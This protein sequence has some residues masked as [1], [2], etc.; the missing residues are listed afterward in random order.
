M[1]PLFSV[2]LALPAYLLAW[3]VLSLVPR[4][5]LGGGPPVGSELLALTATW[6]LSLV[7]LPG[8]YL[9]RALPLGSRR[10][11]VALGVQAAVAFVWALVFWLEFELG[12]GLLAL[13]P[14]WSS[15]PE[16]VAA[17][18]A[19]LL[20]VGMMLS[21]LSMTFH[22]LVLSVQARGAALER[23]AAALLAR[24][25][26]ELGALRA[27]VHP[28][29][30][31][32]SLNTV[33]AL[34]GYDPARAR[35]ACIEL[36][37]YLR[38]TLSAGEHPFT[39]LREEWELAESYLG[40]EALRLGERLQIEPE[41]EPAALDHQVPS[42][43][44][45]PLI[46][47]AITHGV[48]QVSEP[49]PLVLRAQLRGERLLIELENPCVQPGQERAGRPGGLGLANVR[50]RLAAH[51]GSLASLTTTRQAS[52]FRVRLDLPAVPAVGGAA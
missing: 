48:S 46:E 30:L 43:V 45:Q 33:S 35:E 18:R 41:F 39:S 24:Q 12:A 16:V 20:G 19:E 50:A 15:L 8:Y 23:E 21:L 17:R 52:T 4:V 26:A 42:L 25:R 29:F 1:H 11:A 51:Y 27:Q 38:R 13:W 9:C 31:F 28:H 14:A 6:G 40:V 47:N 3:T 34:I 5:V 10:F 7:S 36:G 2:R 44:L 22:H 49:S 32:N 37:S